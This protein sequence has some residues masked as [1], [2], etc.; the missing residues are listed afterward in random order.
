[1]R[2][3][4][5][6]RPARRC[7]TCSRS[8][9]A[10]PSGTALHLD[11]AAR[12]RQEFVDG[13]GA[14]LRRREARRRAA[15]PSG[16][17]A[18]RIGAGFAQSAREPHVLDDDELR[19]GIRRAPRDVLGIVVDVERHD[20]ERRARAPPGR[21]RPT[22][23]RC[24][25]TATTR[26]PAASPSRRNAACQRAISVASS[27]AVTS[28]QSRSDAMAIEDRPRSVR[29]CAKRS[30]MLGMASALAI[31]PP[32]PAVVQR[33]CAYDGA[34]LAILRPTEGRA[35]G[36]DRDREEAPPVA[37]QGEGSGAEDRRRS[38]ATLR[39]RMRRGTATTS[40]SSDRVLRASFT[41]ARAKCASTAS[42][43]FLLSMLKPTIE[44]AVNRDFDK[45]FGK[46]DAKAKAKPRRSQSGRRDAPG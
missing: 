2:Q 17:S 23:G 31:L 6:L 12:R 4:H 16:A 3:H 30:A 33:A 10:S 35:H 21:P 9:R 40:S 41:S 39:P 46:A 19:L 27:P 29:C 34:L 11:L 42:S 26:S 36:H 43:G 18:P 7:P 8:S 25:R 44:D 13:D 24:A 1:M 20:D 15:R 28:R 14:V 38:R 5:A 22:T 32:S 37:R 45:Y